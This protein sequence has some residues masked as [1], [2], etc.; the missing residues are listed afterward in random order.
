[1]K[2]PLS[3]ALAMCVL[4]C[5]HGRGDSVDRYTPG[6][7]YP[8]AVGNS[9]TFSV[10]TLGQTSETTVTLVAKD[11]EFF[12]DS[13]GQRLMLDGSGL[14]DERRYLLQRPL[15]KGTHWKSVVS[16][17]SVE[18]YE[19]VDTDQKVTTPAGSFDGCIVVRS[20]NPQNKD[21]SLINETTFAPGV[22]IVRIE[23]QAVVKGTARKQVSLELTRFKVANGASA[24]TAKDRT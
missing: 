16:V 1:M 17:S 3:A 21:V 12:K 2:A 7:F 22:G 15:V 4:G 18:S 10:N 11:G 9:W 20:T 6:D 24:A 8:L 14:R 19:I 13:T 5:A 23:T